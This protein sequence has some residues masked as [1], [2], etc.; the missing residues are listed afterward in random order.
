MVPADAPTAALTRRLFRWAA[1]STPL[2][3]PTVVIE[4]SLAGAGHSY[5]YL[6]AST[7]CASLAVCATARAL[8]RPATDPARAWLCIALFFVLR[9]TAAS[10]RLFGR[11][12]GFGRWRRSRAEPDAEAA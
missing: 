9:L 7:L 3:V 4:A 2:T 6:A 10:L 12:G 5:R 8:M 11:R 1:L